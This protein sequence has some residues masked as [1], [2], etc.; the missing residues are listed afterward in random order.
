MSEARLLTAK[1]VADYLNVSVPTVRRMSDR[2]ELPAPIRLSDRVVRWDRTQL[3]AYLDRFSGSM[4]YDDPD[5][6][7]AR[8]GPHEGRQAKA[9]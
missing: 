3:D 9:G 8:G 5:E 6:V 7:L 4:G 2:K 1:E